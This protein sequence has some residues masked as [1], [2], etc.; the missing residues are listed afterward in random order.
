MSA[1]RIVDMTTLRDAVS[2]WATHGEI[3]DN[4]VSVLQMA[5]ARMMSDV[6]IRRIEQSIYGTLTDPVLPLPEDVYQ[7]QRLM[8]LDAS[9]AE[10]SLEYAP[11][12]TFERLTG[13]AGRPESFTVLDQALILYPSPNKEYEYA[14]YYIPQVRPL[15]DEN[16]TNDVLKRAP[17]V[18]LYACLS[19]GFNL[20]HDTK[21]AMHFMVMYSDALD[22][23]QSA[24][25]AAKYP[26]S[27][28]L[29]VRLPVTVG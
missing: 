15:T 16:P 3:T 10:R 12:G 28:T 23:L 1:P 2:V 26:L 29:Q 8:L 9:G 19:E 11:P 6:K 22:S 27:S 17:N 14:L 18:Y 4:W 5:E 25:D 7:Y 13:S 24:E 20:V 21:K